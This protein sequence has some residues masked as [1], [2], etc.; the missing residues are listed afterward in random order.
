[1]LHCLMA[2]AYCEHALALDNDAHGELRS[3][4]HAARISAAL[5]A[6]LDA[7][8]ATLEDRVNALSSGVGTVGLNHFAMACYLCGAHKEVKALLAALNR[9]ITLVPWAWIAGGLRE[10]RNLGFVHDRV[11]RELARA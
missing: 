7:S 4:S 6:W 9:E 8:P 10:N 2:L 11:Q 3:A 1:M 5:Y